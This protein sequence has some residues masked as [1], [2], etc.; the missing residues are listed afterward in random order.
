MQNY[1]F[2]MKRLLARQPL[3]GIDAVA[4]KQSASGDSV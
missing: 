4:P 2:W 3:G 1:T